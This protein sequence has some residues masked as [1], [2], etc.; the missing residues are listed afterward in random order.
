LSHRSIGRFGI[1]SIAKKGKRE[2]KVSPNT[3]I[4]SFSTF[5]KKS[6]N[7]NESYFVTRFDKKCPE[8]LRCPPCLTLLITRGKNSRLL[9]GRTLNFKRAVVTLKTSSYSDSNPYPSSFILSSPISD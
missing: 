8:P 7:F 2:M 1:N 4:L 5:D 9:S 6:P 3:E